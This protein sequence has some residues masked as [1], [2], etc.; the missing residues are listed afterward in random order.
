MLERIGVPGAQTYTSGEIVELANLIAWEG[1]AHRQLEE[2]EELR[3]FRD[4]ELRAPH[5]AGTAQAA[6]AI[7]KATAHGGGGAE[8]RSILREF[9]RTVYRHVARAIAEDRVHV[10]DA[11][12]VSPEGQAAVAFLRSLLEFKGAVPTARE[13]VRVILGLLG[14]PL[15]A[16]SASGGVQPFYSSSSSTGPKAEDDGA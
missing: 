2:L 9:A 1:T 7:M 10:A 12:T 11:I 13:H 16:P 14:V 4:Q 3:A 6:D 8:V 5:Y 15:E